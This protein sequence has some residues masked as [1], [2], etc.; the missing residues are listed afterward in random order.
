MLT[1][2][3]HENWKIFIRKT[4]KPKIWTNLDLKNQNFDLVTKLLTIFN[5]ETEKFSSEKPNKP[6]FD[7]F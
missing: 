4:K 6:I 1:V 5:I 3:L 2:F 7:Q